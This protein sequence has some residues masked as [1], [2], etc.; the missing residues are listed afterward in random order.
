MGQG[1]LGT[2]KGG[3]L[4]I[5][6]VGVQYFKNCVVIC[7]NQCVYINFVTAN[8]KIGGGV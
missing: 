8:Y 4:H 7:V 5:E 6:G 2:I 3:T 1:S